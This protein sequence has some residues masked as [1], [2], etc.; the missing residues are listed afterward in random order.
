[1]TL[2]IAIDWLFL[3]SSKHI[4]VGSR[5]LFCKSVSKTLD[6]KVSRIVVES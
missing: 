4:R 1:M 2:S 3:M 5:R 6:D